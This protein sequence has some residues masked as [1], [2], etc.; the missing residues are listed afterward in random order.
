MTSI[1]IGDWYKTLISLRLPG[2]PEKM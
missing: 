2:L 1:Y